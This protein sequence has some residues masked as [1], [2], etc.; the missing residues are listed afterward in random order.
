MAYAVH[1]LGAVL[2]GPTRSTSTRALVAAL[3]GVGHVPSTGSPSSF[4][5]P[6]WCSSPSWAAAWPTRSTSR[7]SDP[8]LEGAGRG[9]RAGVAQD[10]AGAI[11]RWRDRTRDAESGLGAPWSLGAVVV[12]EQL[13]GRRRV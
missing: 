2:H 10:H 7:G 3:H 6:S 4:S 8:A 13:A 1:E 11:L 12:V 5:A 9:S